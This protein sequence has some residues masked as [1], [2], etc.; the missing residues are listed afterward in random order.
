[1]GWLV[2]IGIILALVFMPKN[3]LMGALGIAIALVAAIVAFF[4]FLPE[5]IVFLVISL[6]IISVVVVK[7][8]RG[9]VRK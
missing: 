7:K 8:L 5:S 9:Y 1:M 6:I 2:F 4:V 3:M